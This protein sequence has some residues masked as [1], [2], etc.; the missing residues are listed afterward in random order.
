[1]GQVE[2]SETSEIL[3]ISEIRKLGITFPRFSRFP[4]FPSF[5]FA[6][7]SFSFLFFSPFFVNVFSNSLIYICNYSSTHYFINTVSLRCVLRFDLKYKWI[8]NIEIIKCICKI[9][10]WQNCEFLSIF[11]TKEGSNKYINLLCKMKLWDKLQKE[12]VVEKYYLKKVFVKTS[13][14][15]QEN[16]IVGVSFLVQ[17]VAGLRPESSLKKRL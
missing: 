12:E 11:L 6:T 10:R 3:E 17:M 13:Q 8:H 7:F 15:S 5:R 9:K 1:M 4:T 2:N 16:T 14:N